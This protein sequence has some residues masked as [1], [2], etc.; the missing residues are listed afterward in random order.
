MAM[1]IG[2]RLREARMKRGYKQPQVADEVGQQ[3]RNYQAYE[4]GV[5]RPK[6]ETLAKLATMLDVSTDWLLGLTDE[7]PFDER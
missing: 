5:R 1:N 7:D 6:Y 4:Q 2:I 3:L